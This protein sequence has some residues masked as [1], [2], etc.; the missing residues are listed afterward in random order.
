MKINVDLYG[1]KGLFGC[2]ESPL[3]A[4]IISCDRVDRCTFYKDGTCL[5]CRSFLAP[6]C[7]FGSVQTVKGYTSRARKYYD[8]KNKYTSD[9][10]YNKLKYPTTLIAVMG[11]TLYMNLKYTL[12]RKETDNNK[13]SWGTRYNGYIISEVGFCTG[14]LFIPMSEVTTDLLNA[15]FSYSPRAMMGGIITDYKNKVVPDIIQSMRKV[16]PDLYYEL[17]TDYSKYNVAPNYIGK[18]AYINSFKV[19]TKF[20]HKS[21]E[22][23]Y[24]GEYVATNDFN[25]GVSSPWWTQDG[26]YSSVKIKVNDKMTIEVEDNSIIDDEVK[27][28]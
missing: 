7:K 8:F 1:G 14:D 22:W 15:I 23:L 28:V 21:K 3:E 5:R 9:E 2:K 11:D 17:I 16:A 6:T 4:D 18:E 25:L 20:K 12:V 13:D 19:G 24:D 26:K 27:F 10:A